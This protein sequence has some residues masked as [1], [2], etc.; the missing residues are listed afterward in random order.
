[1]HLCR[2]FAGRHTREVSQNE[3]LAAGGCSVSPRDFPKGGIMT[4]VALILVMFFGCST[5]VVA[6]KTRTT[7]TKPE[8]V[9]VATTAQMTVFG[10]ALGQ[11]YTVPACDK[12]ARDTF[13]KVCVYDQRDSKDGYR[14]INFPCCKDIPRLL[15]NHHNP[16]ALILDGKLEGIEFETSG[17]TD[18]D[19][20]MGELKQKYGKPA[21]VQRS[22]V[23]NQMGGQFE[24]TDAVWIFS[25]LTVTFYAV[26]NRT[27][28]G[29]VTIYTNQGKAA[30][31]L[32]RQRDN[33][34]RTPF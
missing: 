13:D 22:A 33:Q 19:V 4:K 15:Y 17:V 27:D 32:G 11:L 25:D 6:Q 8:E 1:M 14:S 34:Q 28:E 3:M 18:Q 24:V 2:E 10:L 16:Q 9:P 31:K 20:V 26:V 21:F 5:E 30:V 12:R 29:A 7:A 23:A